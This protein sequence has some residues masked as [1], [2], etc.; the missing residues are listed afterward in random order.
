MNLPRGFHDCAS[1]APRAHHE[2]PIGNV[3]VG[4]R[5]RRELCAAIISGEVSVLTQQLASLVKSSRGAVY[6]PRTRSEDK[7][8]EQEIRKLID[9]LGS[10]EF[11]Q[12]RSATLRLKLL[13]EPALP[14]L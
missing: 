12:R 9:Q 2:L 4:R 8:T 13:G 1:A 3:A 10:Q 7:V 5:D 6:N 14:L 11:K